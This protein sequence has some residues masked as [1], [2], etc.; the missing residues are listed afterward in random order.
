[1]YVYFFQES[2]I[3]TSICLHR[4]HRSSLISLPL[5]FWLVVPVCGGLR[6]LNR[7][8]EYRMTLH[9]YFRVFCLR[10]ELVYSILTEL[11]VPVKLVILIDM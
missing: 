11:G 9:Q 2:I 6:Y 7:K 8:W 4:R 10:R 3:C 5:A 1:M